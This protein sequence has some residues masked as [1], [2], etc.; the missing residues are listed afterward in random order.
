[1]PSSKAKF[2]PSADV[3]RA[4]LEKHHD[5]D[6]ELVLGFYKKEFARGITHPE[7]LDEALTFGWID[8][9]VRRLD[10][11]SYSIRFSP[12]G[13]SSVWSQVN[14]RRV[15]ELIR[16]DR[17]KPPGMRAFEARDRQKTQQYSYENRPKKLGP[18][19]EKILRAS[20]KAA[21]FFD[22]QPPGYR[23]LM[24]FW[25]MEAKKDETRARRLEILIKHSARG[26]RIDLMKPD[27]G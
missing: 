20:P 22:A 5:K 12:R 8:G 24:I 15:E 2:F 14:T 1:M 23:K 18:P 26:A 7:A 13:K 10:A 27:R 4:W 6:R 17:M 3:F 9:V 21:A 25:I 19:Q 11:K 16:L